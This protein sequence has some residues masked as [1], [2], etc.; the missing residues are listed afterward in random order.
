MLSLVRILPVFLAFLCLAVSASAAAQ[1]PAA[2]DGLTGSWWDPARSG[3]GLV[4]EQVSFPD[5]ERADQL[6]LYWFTYADDGTPLYLVGAG[7]Y[8]NGFVSADLVRT[9]GGRH[10]RE[11]D[12]RMVQRTHWGR[13]RVEAISCESIRVTSTPTGGA[14]WQI[15]MSRVSA[16]VGGSTSRSSCEMRDLVLGYPKIE[17]LYTHGSEP[18]WSPVSIPFKQDLRLGQPDPS[19]ESELV[20]YRITAERGDVVVGYVWWSFLAVGYRP[21]WVGLRLGETIEEGATREISLRAPPGAPATMFMQI[22]IGLH[23][24]GHKGGYDS[25]TL[26]ENISWRG[27]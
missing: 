12:P 13:I 17:R 23:Y 7:E 5:A 16:S 20:R 14:T 4:I 3:Q 1:A 18:F 22:R 27:F 11:L 25:P 15:E 8:L 21:Y 24:E 9:Q 2:P 10:G 19:K 26:W 6:H